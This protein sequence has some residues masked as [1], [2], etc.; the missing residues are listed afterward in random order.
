[1]ATLDRTLSMLKI[2]AT[3]D[4]LGSKKVGEVTAMFN[5]ENI[6]LNYNVSIED[7]IV[8]SSGKNKQILSI[9]D[10]PPGEM[11]IKLLYDAT[12][13]PAAV[14][15]DMQIHALRGLCM[16]INE[17]TGTTSFLELSWGKFTWW[18][19]KTLRCRA[20]SMDVTYQLFDHDATP[21]RAEVD[22]TFKSLDE[23]SSGQTSSAQSTTTMKVPDKASLPEVAS[24]L[25][26]SVEAGQKEYL[27]VAYEN[28]LDHLADITPGKIL[29]APGTGGLHG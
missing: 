25:G 1:M 27:K 18:A 4:E 19:G 9:K 2:R 29:I 16:A 28:N 17:K 12:L 26:P 14:S 8:T 23:D 13:S 5:P 20:S 21:L 10:A 11:S 6:R 3:F 7:Q 22:M 24:G 15:I